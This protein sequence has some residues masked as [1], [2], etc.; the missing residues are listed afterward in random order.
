MPWK[1]GLASHG[2]AIAIIFAMIWYARKYGRK[3]GFEFWWVMDHIVI[4]TCFA[5]AMIRLG[6]LF[7][8]EIYGNVTSL[9]W[10]FVY[11][12]NGETLPKH[13]TQ[14]YEALGY[15]ILGAVLS[16]LY[17]KKADKLY[18]GEIF[19]IFF[20]ALW[21]IR[22]LIEFVKEPQV[23]FEQNMTL[24]MGQLLSI[25]FIIAGIV[26]LVVSLIK[27]KPFLAAQAVKSK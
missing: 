11:E 10:G 7:N 4:P 9:P 12:L 2:G 24:N 18:R 16:W 26:I 25:P 13:P 6:N 23:M 3:N 15:T 27:K 1:G 20:I 19:G 14:L 22:F 5:G 17:Y 21:G 8:S